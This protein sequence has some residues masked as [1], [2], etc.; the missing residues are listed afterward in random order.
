MGKVVLQNKSSMLSYHKLISCCSSLLKIAFTKIRHIFGMCLQILCKLATTFVEREIEK[1][2][3][4]FQATV[5][6][7]AIIGTDIVRSRE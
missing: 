1:Y 6:I 4:K 7:D 5:L 2:L 3:F